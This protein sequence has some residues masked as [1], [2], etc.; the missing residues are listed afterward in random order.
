MDIKQALE[1]I[2]DVAE[3]QGEPML[4]TLIYM[5]SNLDDFSESE[6]KAFRIV[7]RDFQKLFA[8]EA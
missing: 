8:V 1:V 7:M 6:V 3:D 4:E 5:Q 2:E